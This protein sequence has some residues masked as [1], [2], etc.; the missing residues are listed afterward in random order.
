MITIFNLSL[1]LIYVYI[2]ATYSD[3]END[4]ENWMLCFINFTF[5][6]NYFNGYFKVIDKIIFYT[7][8]NASISA[9]GRCIE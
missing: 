1:I 2:L 5:D 3:I 6:C 7:K 4:S 9:H 8:I